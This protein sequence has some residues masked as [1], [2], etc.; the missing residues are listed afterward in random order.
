MCIESNFTEIYLTY[1][2][3]EKQIAGNRSQAKIDENR[4]DEAVLFKIEKNI[5]EIF[6][7]MFLLSARVATGEE[8]SIEHLGKLAEGVSSEFD[9][10]RLVYSH[11]LETI[12]GTWRK[13]LVRAREEE[14]DEIALK[15]S[16]KCE[17]VDKL[18]S[19]FSELCEKCERKGS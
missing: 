13:S 11:F 2:R 8:K 7:K 1:L 4:N 3:T 18:S 5:F 12:P 16:V 6:E 19:F 10:L 9:R 17:A 14:N 15:E